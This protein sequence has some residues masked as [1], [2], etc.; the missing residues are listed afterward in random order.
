MTLVGYAADLNQLVE[1]LRKEYQIYSTHPDL[2]ANLTRM[3]RRM[4]ELHTEGIIEGTRKSGPPGKVTVYPRVAETEEHQAMT[5]IL[6]EY[7][8]LFLLHK[9]TADQLLE[10]LRAGGRV[11]SFDRVRIAIEKKFGNLHAAPFPLAA[12]KGEVL[13]IGL[14]AGLRDGIHMLVTKF[15][16]TPEEA[17]LKMKEIQ[18]ELLDFYVDEVA[19][20]FE[21]SP[22]KLEEFKAGKSFVRR[23]YK[24]PE[25]WGEKFFPRNGEMNSAEFLYFVKRG[26][27]SEVLEELY[28]RFLL[29][30]RKTTSAS[31]SLFPVIE[32]HLR[33]LSERY[34]EIDEAI[35]K[36]I[37]RNLIAN[38]FFSNKVACWIK[39]KGIVK[40]FKPDGD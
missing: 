36:K 15:I 16:Q 33:T 39:I 31:Q 12:A 5:K 37:G 40:G 13:E 3:A 24:F 26:E 25:R 23:F 30:S 1:K 17:L 38:R 20:K 10:Y 2:V 9:P 28:R 21:L 32:G 27:P 19:K 22:S 4:Q 18:M 35:Q 34:P 11:P 8:Q 6:A 29:A 14:E 7:S